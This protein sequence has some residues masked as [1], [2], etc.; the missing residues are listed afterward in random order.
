MLDVK[1]GD[2]VS[3]KCIELENDYTTREKILNL[4]AAQNPEDESKG[5][6]GIP[7]NGIAKIE[8]RPLLYAIPLQPIAL[9]QMASPRF[10]EYSGSVAFWYAIFLLK[11]VA[12]L[13]F[14]IG[15]VNLLPVGGLDGGLIARDLLD[16]I[17]PRFGK[18]AFKGLT[19]LIL[20]FL[21]MNI[22][23]YFR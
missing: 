19:Y 20:L 12:F 9:I 7:E 18:H 4:T 14:A 3:F 8:A 1:P 22:L 6:L 5:Y 16:K 21:L 23:P 2:V 15:I 13:N 17:S 11:W 10:F